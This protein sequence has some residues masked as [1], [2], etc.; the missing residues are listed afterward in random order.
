MNAAKKP[1]FN[2]LKSSSKEDI[3]GKGGFDLR[4]S[5]TQDITLIKS[6]KREENTPTFAA[7][8]VG[9]ELQNTPAVIPPSE[10]DKIFFSGQQTDDSGEIDLVIDDKPEGEESNDNED[11]VDTEE[12]EEAGGLSG[13]NVA[14]GLY[15][16]DL[17]GMMKTVENPEAASL[18]EREEAGRVLVEVLQTD[19]FEQVVSG[20]PQKKVAAGKLM[21]NYF[22]DFY[23]HKR[24]AGE[25]TDEL[26]VKAPNDF[27]VRAF[28]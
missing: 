13:I 3:V 17:S 7:E 8:N 22:A 5:L 25:I 9:G 18:E 15:F 16:D 4:H 14:S 20:E 6:E 28:A 1:A 24:E 26:S 23:R 12:S 21:D 19:M 10:L 11:Y 27:D 2:P